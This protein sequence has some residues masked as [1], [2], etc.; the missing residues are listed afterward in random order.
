LIALLK[1]FFHDKQSYIDIE[2]Y[3]PQTKL[4][5]AFQ[6]QHEWYEDIIEI[7]HE[8]PVLSFGISFICFV[9]PAFIWTAIYF[10][11]ES[12]N[13]LANRFTDVLDDASQKQGKNFQDDKSFKGILNTLP[14][15]MKSAAEKAVSNRAHEFEQIELGIQAPD[16][17]SNEWHPPIW[18]SATS[19]NIKAEEKIFRVS[20]PLSLTNH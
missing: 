14:D 15:S 12:R 17:G 9:I 3:Y 1:N 19:A 18:S 16:L 20:N 11:T 5:D 13:V 4:L 8:H 6:K 10:G 7:V 2:F